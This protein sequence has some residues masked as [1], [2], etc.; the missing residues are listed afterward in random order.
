MVLQVCTS[1][2]GE[3]SWWPVLEKIDDEVPVAVTIDEDDEVDA[4]LPE[5][6]QSANSTEASEAK[7]VNRSHGRGNAGCRGISECTATT[8]FLEERAHEGEGNK[9]RG[10]ILGAD[11]AERG[12]LALSPQRRGLARASRGQG[13]QGEDLVRLSWAGLG[14]LGLGGE[15]QGPFT[16]FGFLLFIFRALNQFKK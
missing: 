3:G 9:R 8:V 7:L 4:L 5:T 12:G 11:E 2:L 14:S 6:K 10:N 15:R 16:F 13:E 1:G